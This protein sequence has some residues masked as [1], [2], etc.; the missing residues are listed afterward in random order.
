MKITIKDSMTVDIP[1]MFVKMESLPEDPQDSVSYGIRDS[2]TGSFLM[3]YPIPN[4]QAMPLTEPQIIIDSIHRFMNENQG[5]I[6]VDAG[7]TESGHIYAYSIV[8]NLKEPS[9]VQYILTFQIEH[10]AEVINV[11][12]FFDEMGMTGMRDAMVY[13]K[14]VRDGFVKQGSFDGWSCDPYDPDYTQGKPMNLSEDERYDSSFPQHP[15]SE[16]RSFVR[17]LI[18]NN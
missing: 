9:G 2:G 4:A 13:D 17:Y 14:A 8:K 15:L 12:A 7:C 3:I 18:E 6:K 10:G 11:Q 5:L 16:A 1:D